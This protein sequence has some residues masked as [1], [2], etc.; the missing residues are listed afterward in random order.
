MLSQGINPTVAIVGA[1]RVGRALGR[2]LHELGWKIGAV[3]TRSKKSARAAVRAIGSGQAHARL[4]RQVVG[5]DL[6]LITTPDSAL[7]RVAEELALIGGDELCGKLVLH[8]SGALDRRVLASLERLGAATGSLHPMQTFSGHAV[9]HLEGTMMAVEGT[10][11]ALR[12]ARQIARSLGGIPMRID[13]RNK[14]A[15]HAAGSLVAGHALALME[16]A[17]R[18]LM[19]LKFTRRHTMRALLPLVRQMLDNFERL[20]PRV[21]WTGPL[22][23]GDYTTIA[24]HAEAMRKFPREFRETYAVLSR[25]AM[26]LFSPEPQKARRR[27]ARA[28]AAKSSKE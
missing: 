10:P 16:A 22:P 17:T 18:V 4:T 9:P 12:R 5:A 14:A 20:G 8:T 15:Y 26:T 25:L 13:G 28:L 21:A 19:S 1:G 3:V 7:G 23:R 11:V 6:I 27:L 24:A 2:R